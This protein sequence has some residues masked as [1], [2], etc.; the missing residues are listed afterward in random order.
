MPSNNIHFFS[1]VVVTL[2]RFD[3]SDRECPCFRSLAKAEPAGNNRTESNISVIHIQKITLKDGGADFDFQLSSLS[4]NQLKA[5]QNELTAKQNEL[6]KAN[7]I[8]SPI[9]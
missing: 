6:T 7:K 2:G 8:N 1:N 5:K 3:V 9:K 4:E